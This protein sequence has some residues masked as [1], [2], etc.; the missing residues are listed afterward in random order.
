MMY[1]RYTI[2]RCGC[3]VVAIARVRFIFLHSSTIVSVADLTHPNLPAHNK[4]IICKKMNRT[5][6]AHVVG[7]DFTTRDGHWP[8]GS[9]VAWEPGPQFE[10]EPTA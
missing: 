2:K 1:I 7:R 3:T 10:G 8:G 4:L 6:I 5:P 9:F